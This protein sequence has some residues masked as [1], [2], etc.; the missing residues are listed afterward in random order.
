MECL[1][2][3]EPARSGRLMKTNVEAHKKWPCRGQRKHKATCWHVRTIKGCHKKTEHKKNKSHNCG[4]AE[5]DGP[6]LRLGSCPP[7]EPASPAWMGWK[8]TTG[9]LPPPPTPEYISMAAMCAAITVKTFICLGLVAQKQ[10]LN[11]F[12]AEPQKAESC[13][14]ASAGTQ[15]VELAL[16]KGHYYFKKKL[17]DT[18]AFFGALKDFYGL[19][20]SLACWPKIILTFLPPP[21]PSPLP[22][23]WF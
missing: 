19:C 18:V 20:C 17:W 5:P 2:T 7:A 21:L 3:I 4:A 6:R 13:S 8:K 1:R 12:V 22:E 23:D 15:T 10:Q 9:C 14:F 16:D 11:V